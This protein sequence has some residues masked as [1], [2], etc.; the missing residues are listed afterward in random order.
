MSTEL[1]L[2]G[3]CRTRTCHRCSLDVCMCGCHRPIKQ[4]LNA[5]GV[6]DDV[7]DTQR[8][9]YDHPRFNWA[10]FY[11]RVLSSLINATIYGGGVVLLK[12]LGVL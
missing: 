9:G 8:P 7:E 6:N 5:L 11:E 3:A 10:R 4:A 1:I 12:G 2:S